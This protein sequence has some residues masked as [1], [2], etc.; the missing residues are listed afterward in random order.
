MSIEDG[1]FLE[2]SQIVLEA[3]GK[4]AVIDGLSITGNQF[5][6]GGTEPILRLDESNGQFG[7][8]TQ[9]TVRDNLIQS[10]HIFVQPRVSDSVTQSERTLYEFDFKKQL[11][12]D[13]GVIEIAWVEYTVQYNDASFTPHALRRPNGTTVVVEFEQKTSATVYLT[14]DQST[15]EC[16]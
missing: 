13:T 11:L 4:A 12:F 14:V 15:S 6:Y 8:V 3:A 9:M 7:S 10:G 5:L 16:Y 1:F 2:G